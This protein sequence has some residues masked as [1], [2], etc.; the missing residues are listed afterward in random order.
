[1]TRSKEQTADTIAMRARKAHIPTSTPPHSRDSGAPSAPVAGRFDRLDALRGFAL[2]W[3]A[4]FHFCFDLS[5]YRLLD[6]NFYQDALWT[7]QR[8]LILSLFLLCAGA[9]QAVATSQGQSWARFWRRWAQVLGCALLVSLGSWFMFPRSYISFGVLHG[10]AVMLIVARVSAPL[11]GWLWPL[12]LLA[13]NL[14]QFIQHPFFD[15]RLTNWVGL[16]THK[17]I[18]EDYVPLLPWIGALLTGIAMARFLVDGNRLGWIA[19]L[20]AGPAW[21]RWGGRHSL[22]VYLLHQPILIAGLYLASFVVPPPTAD[23]SGPPSPPPRRQAWPPYPRSAAP[24]PNRSAPSSRRSARA[25]P[26]PAGQPASPR[27]AARWNTSN[28]AAWIAPCR[29]S[30]NS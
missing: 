18:T 20:P 16:V 5:T 3:M 24:R 9:G 25:D 11:R 29:R 7:T 2:V 19:R 12:G 27:T 13:V 17:P 1:M 23:P 10:M 22:T 6:A 15:T 4:V 8:T 28:R 21:L 30:A 14:P 26:C